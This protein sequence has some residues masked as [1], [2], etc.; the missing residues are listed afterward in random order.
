MPDQVTDGYFWIV[1]YEDKMNA[2]RENSGIDQLL[3][4]PLR[5]LLHACLGASELEAYLISLSC[6]GLDNSV[7]GLS[8]NYPWKSILAAFDRDV[9]QTRIYYDE[10]LGEWRS[11]SGYF[12]WNRKTGQV[13]INYGDETNPVWRQVIPGLFDPKPAIP[14]VPWTCPT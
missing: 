2:T 10:A 7:A 14:Q 6:V 9:E 4:I 1:L 3:E 5:E 11:K 12:R 8:R 13:W